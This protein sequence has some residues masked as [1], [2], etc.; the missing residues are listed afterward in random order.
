MTV[1]GPAEV[2]VHMV[3]DGAKLSMLMIFV[4]FVVTFLPPESYSCSTLLIVQVA[5][6]DKDL[7]SSLL[8]FVF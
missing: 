1:P 4:A 6:G 8:L 5:T 3:C 7:G 2:G